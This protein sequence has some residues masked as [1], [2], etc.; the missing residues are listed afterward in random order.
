MSIISKL[1]AFPKAI[2]SILIDGEN[3]FMAIKAKIFMIKVPIIMTNKFSNRVP[4]TFV[5]ILCN[6]LYI[7]CC[8][9]KHIKH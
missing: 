3:I 9:S 7:D 6:S 8:I 1:L 5:I 2:S 4:I